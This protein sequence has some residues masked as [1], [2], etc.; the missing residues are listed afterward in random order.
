MQRAWYY[1]ELFVDP[2]NENRIYVLSAPALRSD[3]GGKTWED[4]ESPHGDYHDMWINPDDPD[5]FIIA[6]DGGAT[7]T[8]DGGKSWSSQANMPTAQFYRINVDN[9]FPYRIYGGQ[10]DNTSVVIASREL[11]RPTASPPTSWTSSAG[12]ESAFL[13][14]DPDNPRYV[15]GGSYEGTIEVSTPRRTPARTSCRRRSST[16]AW[17]PRT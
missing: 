7:I 14:F 3:D 13:A 5:N 11:G 2:K 12:G 4:V 17:T 15:M 8:F 6:N 10:Q 16:S 1:I 9:R